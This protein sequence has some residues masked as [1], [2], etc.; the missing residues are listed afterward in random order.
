MTYTLTC[1]ECECPEPARDEFSNMAHCNACGWTWEPRPRD[2]KSENEIKS[3]YQ[4]VDI[5]V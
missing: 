5:E 2:W 3:L 1:P 4:D